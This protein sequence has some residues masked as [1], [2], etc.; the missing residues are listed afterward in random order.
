VFVNCA[1]SVFADDSVLLSNAR[2]VDPARRTENVGHILIRGN[3]I[4]D[5]LQEAPS[6]FDGETVDLSGKFIIPGLV[7]AHVHSEGNRGPLEQRGES[8]WVEETARRMLY[9]GVTA[10]LDVGLAPARIFPVR[11][12][13]RAGE[14]LGA[15]VYAAGP[16]FMGVAFRDPLGHTASVT[17]PEQV[18]AAL[19]DLA[20]SKPDVVKIIFDWAARKN[21]MSLAIMRSLVESSHELKLKT[22]VH[23]GTWA[24]ARLAAE[25]GA[26]AITHFY[27]TAPVPEDVARLFAERSVVFI[28]TM[29][30]QEDFLNILE[31][32][33]LLDN[34]LLRSVTS[35]AL[36]EMY[37]KMEGVANPDCFTCRWQREG[38]KHYATSLHRLRD[39]GVSIVAGSDT[40]N[41]G[42]F[43][44]FS[45]H[46]ELILLNRS[47]LDTWDALA[48]GTT[49][50]YRFLGLNM[51]IERGADATLLVLG[52]SPIENIANT[53][54][55]ERILFHGKWVDRAALAVKR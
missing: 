48:A 53:Q 15:D 10:Y 44:G 36:L 49:R 27:D 14:L 33:A 22:V 31:D 28:P 18:R 13:L 9:C 1:A 24:N 3:K 8:F 32:R 20:R 11:E 39:A 2:I 29:A 12:R 41:I 45:L 23:I 43:Q 4:V 38:R 50:A 34:T 54:S 52:A 35:D 19:A 47:G 42:T 7:D 55:I 46:R 30:V 17:T 21:T 26:T 5:V 16:A 51:G 6:A 25:A 40:G 37:R